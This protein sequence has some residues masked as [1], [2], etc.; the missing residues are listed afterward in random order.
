MPKRV[1][2]W[3]ASEVKAAIWDEKNGKPIAKSYSVGG[4]KGLM[5]VVKPTGAKSWVLRTTVC[6]VRRDIGIGGYPKV[7]LSV[8]RQLALKVIAD[9]A[10][11]IDPLEQKRSK[12]LEEKRRAQEPTFEEM[13]LEFIKAKSPEW[14]NLKHAQQWR[15]TLT[16]YAFPVIGKL[17]VSKVDRS[18]VLAILKP[19]WNT[20]SETASR[21][22]GRIEN[23][24][25]MAKAEGWR[26]GE[27]P[28][29]W[30]DNL[31]HSL[32]S[33]TKRKQQH[34]PALP[35][36][37]ISEFVQAMREATAPCS[38]ALLFQIL[39]ASRSGMVLGAR[40][41]EIDFESRSWTIPADRMKTRE[42]FR[43]ALSDDAIGLLRKLRQ[44]NTNE[45]VF[46]APRGGAFSD[47][48]LSKWIKDDHARRVA[49]GLSGWIDPKQ[50]NRIIVPHGFRSTFRDWASDT[51]KNFKVAE[52][53]LAHAEGNAVTAAYA[54]SDLFEQ[55]LQLMN[56][57]SSFCYNNQPLI[58]TNKWSEYG[59]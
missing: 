37:R 48:S 43:C 38:K 50:E 25:S 8:A 6:G 53:A 10:Q 1:V 41:S 4:A 14:S 20:K 57:W 5:L 12:R 24:L 15:N 39:T 31:Q 56:E 30:A 59:E 22:R 21:L 58:K 17:P 16:Q 33:N 26:S 9:V 13:A 54:R 32:S 34:F 51:G 23:V 35:W 2:E 7:P 47:M 18:H 45:L 49:Q 11:G 40:W 42:L 52:A 27:N 36:V 44:N 3:T 29:I 55:R 28:A 19:I 46:P